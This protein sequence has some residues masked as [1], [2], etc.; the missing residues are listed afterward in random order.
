MANGGWHGTK[1]EW[2]RIESP[3][4]EID[5]DLHQFSKKYGLLLTKNCKDWPERSLTW[6]TDV[7]C[8]IQIFLVDAKA[9]TFNLWICASQDRSDSRFWKQEMPCKEVSITEIKN[10]FLVRL[11]EGKRKIDYWSQHPEVLEFVTKLGRT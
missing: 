10:N 5:S 8:L 7:Q 1:E 2:D 3:L 9:L 11:E 4:K 6:A